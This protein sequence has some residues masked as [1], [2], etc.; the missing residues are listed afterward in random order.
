MKKVL[1]TVLTLIAFAQGA[2]SPALGACG[3]PNPNNTCGGSV[4]CHCGDTVV[5]S[6]NLDSSDPVLRTAC[7]DDGLYVASGVTLQINGT[8]RDLPNPR[9]DCS[10]I[11]VGVP[12]ATGATRVVVKIGTIVGFDSGV[13]AGD[14]NGT[15]GG[16]K[17]TESQ[18]LRLQIVDSADTGIGL[19]GDNNVIERNIITSENISGGQAGILVRTGS[20]NTVSLNRTET[21]GVDGIKLQGGSDNTVSR[22][23]SQRS[24]SSSSGFRIDGNRATVDRNTSKDNSADGFTISGTNHTVT[25]NIAARNADNGFSVGA[26]GSTF[27]SNVSKYNGGFGIEDVTAPGPGTSG[28]SNFYTA[29]LCTGNGMGTSNPLGLCF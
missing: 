8:I 5:A 4:P 20:H 22:N 16:G 10:G 27:T 15:S 29:N 12:G 7:P 19:T 28:T 1:L 11:V 9:D 23:L 25:R 26:T 24:G 2:V 18:F 14:F 6:R 21:S 13:E 3:V 17:V